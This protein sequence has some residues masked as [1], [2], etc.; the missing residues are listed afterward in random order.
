MPK[1]KAQNEQPNLGRA[2]RQRKAVNVRLK[3]DDAISIR[4]KS[5]LRFIF[6]C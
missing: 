6:A 3:P 1:T 5:D 2:K 4:P